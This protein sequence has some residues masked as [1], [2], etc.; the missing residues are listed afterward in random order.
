MVTE[1]RDDGHWRT[2]FKENS[3]AQ[4]RIPFDLV[5]STTSQ[6]KC[7]LQEFVE[8]SQEKPQKQFY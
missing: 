1:S 3:S 6:L 2:L 7:N 5:I 8:A 4:H